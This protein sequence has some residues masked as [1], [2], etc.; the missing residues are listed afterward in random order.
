MD[1]PAVIEAHLA[2]ATRHLAEPDRHLEKQR[3]IVVTL[4]RD[5]HDASLARELSGQGLPFFPLRR[6]SDPTNE[7]GL[8][9]KRVGA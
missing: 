3:S 2:A 4:E 5:G 7:S 6:P 9:T 1:E 8:V